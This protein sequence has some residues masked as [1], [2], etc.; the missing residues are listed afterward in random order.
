MAIRVSPSASAS[1]GPQARQQLA[2]VGQAREERVALAAAATADVAERQ[3]PRAVGRHAAPVERRVHA[4]VG[5]V[6]RL[7]VEQSQPLGG[8]EVCRVGGRVQPAQAAREPDARLG[9][10]IAGMSAGGG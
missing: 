4:A 5:V 6:V 10:Q 8:R 2:P 1:T 3:R 9:R 7:H